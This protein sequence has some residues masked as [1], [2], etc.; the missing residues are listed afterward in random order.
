MPVFLFKK[1]LKTYLLGGIAAFYS[2]VF[3]KQYNQ[4]DN[5][6]LKM[7]AKQNCKEALPIIFTFML[8]Q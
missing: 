2:Q 5:L 7:I 6:K 4:H 8:R 1:G 3:L